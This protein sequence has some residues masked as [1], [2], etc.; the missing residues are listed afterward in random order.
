[1]NLLFPSPFFRVSFFSPSD[2]ELLFSFAEEALELL[3][4]TFAPVLSPLPLGTFAKNIQSRR[5][6]H[7]EASGSFAQI[8]GKSLLFLLS[9]LRTS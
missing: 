3:R 1:M 5:L 4:A 9:F 2:C 8:F 6:S 7:T